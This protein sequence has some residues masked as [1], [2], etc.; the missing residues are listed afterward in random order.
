[1]TRGAVNY[2]FAAASEVTVWCFYLWVL[3]QVLPSSDLGRVIYVLVFSACVGGILTVGWKNWLQETGE[4]A[5]A[6]AATAWSAAVA[7]LVA[8]CMIVLPVMTMISWQVGGKVLFPWP[9]MPVMI[10]VLSAF[11][12]LLRLSGFALRRGEEPGKIAVLTGP[13]P[14]LLSIAGILVLAETRSLRFD[15]VLGLHALCLL[16]VLMLAARRLPALRWSGE[17]PTAA[18]FLDSM[19]EAG[20][21]LFRNV[22]VMVIGLVLTPVECAIYLIA[23]SVAMS[24]D[25]LFRVLSR[26]LS[27][28]IGRSYRHRERSRFVAQSARAN[29]GFLLIGGAGALLLFVSAGPVLH[30]FGINSAEGRQPLI[31]LI[32]AQSAPALFGATHMFMAMTRLETIRAWIVWAAMPFALILV[33]SAA[34]EGLVSL[35]AT[36]AALQVGVAAVCAVVVALRCGIWP[37]LTAMFHSRI[38]LW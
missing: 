16:V 33:F 14:V 23:R 20:T 9:E 32:I 19:A 13:L 25:L 37:G 34:R 7:G 6:D 26:A 15:V 22:D 24:L 5:G 35:A 11:F 28:P 17:L 8:R 21:I 27:G 10:A 12:A 3:T 1:M 29:L 4:R 38:R 18:V 36:Y 30:L 2:A 31:Y